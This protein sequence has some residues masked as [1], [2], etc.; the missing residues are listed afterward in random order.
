MP[1][2][3]AHAVA[4]PPQEGS[5]A[6][7][8]DHGHKEVVVHGRHGAV[9]LSDGPAARSNSNGEEEEEEEEDEEDEEEEEIA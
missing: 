9:E 8:G 4:A 5:D 7:C 6:R 3:D 2:W 1:P